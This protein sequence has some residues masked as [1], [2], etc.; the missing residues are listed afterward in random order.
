MR[1]TLARLA[2]SALRAVF[3]A[4]LLVRRPRPIH[5]KGLVLSGEIS[6]LGNTRARSGIRW[7]DE[8]P[9]EPV[10]VVARL[11]RSIGLPTWA[12]DVIG[13]ALRVDAEAQPGGPRRPIDLELASTGF[14]VPSRYLLV[15]HRSPS[16]ARLGTLL[17]YRTDRGPVLIGAR[18][19]TPRDLPAERR[20]Q[21]ARLSQEPWV[22]RLYHARPTGKW[23]PFAEVSLR[24]AADQ[25]DSTLRFDSVRH[26]LP[27]AQIYDW[28]RA[29]HQPAYRLAQDAGARAAVRPR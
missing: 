5:V 3:A 25:G 15:P 18:T 10:A 19:L 6:W 26:P 8:P 16:R 29:V 20:S 14:G 9:G 21:A 24:R 2:G 11:S 12:P 23:H 27:G 13:L 17:P 4:I 22:L 7:I 1:L 28:M